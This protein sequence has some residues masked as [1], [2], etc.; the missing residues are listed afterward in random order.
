MQPGPAVA[1]SSI[2]V[3]FKDVA[4]S[5]KSC[6]YMLMKWKIV[7]LL[8]SSEKESLTSLDKEHDGVEPIVFTRCQ[9]KNDRIIYIL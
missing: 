9:L 4:A 3:H 7:Y 1:D 8:I 6:Y 5:M 2:K